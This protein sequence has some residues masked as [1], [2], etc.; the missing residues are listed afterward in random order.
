M[1]SNEIVEDGADVCTQRLEKR[2]WAKAVD[3]V[4]DEIRRERSKLTKERV[5]AW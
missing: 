1:Q 2:N 3:S 4:V 5:R